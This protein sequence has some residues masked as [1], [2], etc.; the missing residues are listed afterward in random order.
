MTAAQARRRAA[1]R[2]RRRRRRILAR[3]LILLPALLCAAGLAADV[4][5]VSKDPVVHAPF[6]PPRVSHTGIR[7]SQPRV[8]IPVFHPSILLEALELK[9][10]DLDSLLLEPRDSRAERSLAR[11]RIPLPERPPEPGREPEFERM[12]AELIQVSAI[13]PHLLEMVLP[14]PHV[15]PSA[16]PLGDFLL[17]DPRWPVGWPG[18]GWIDFPIVL[19]DLPLA[20][21]PPDSRKKKKDEDEEEEEEPPPPVP[22]PGTAL[23]LVL[24]LAL[25]G[26]AGRKRVRPNP[27]S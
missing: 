18:I 8:P 13:Q 23:L 6:P 5:Q 22:E 19:V 16:A 10:P 3:A 11:L 24:G 15:D 2:I 25:F 21:P 20:K 14:R 9:V 1:R 17:L 12:R 4:I 26:I 27:S 7:A